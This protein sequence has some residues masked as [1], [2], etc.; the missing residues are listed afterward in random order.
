MNSVLRS[1]LVIAATC[2]SALFLAVGPLDAHTGSGGPAGILE[3]AHAT[4]LFVCSAGLTLVGSKLP[5]WF[6]VPVFAALVLAA[7]SGLTS[8]TKQLIRARRLTS[9]LGRTEVSPVP[10]RLRWIAARAGLERRVRLAT[11]DDFVAFCSGLLRP[12]VWISTGV[13]EDLSTV[14]VEAILRHEAWHARQ[15]D[16]LKVLVANTIGAAFFFVPFVKDCGRCYVLAKELDADAVAV[17]DMEDVLPLASALYQALS[18]TALRPQVHPAV[19][20]FNAIDA[21][22]DQ[23]V[24]VTVATVTFRAKFF[25]LLSA[26]FTAASIAV[27]LCL[28]GFPP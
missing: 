5:A 3:T 17:R 4:I 7:V 22:I 14:E 20:A 11:S 2:G 1:S 18:A 24:G 9:L 16:P 23:L 25:A 27:V 21:R 28:V 12:E 8:A 6:E 19:G 13:L 26:L 10:A 15:R